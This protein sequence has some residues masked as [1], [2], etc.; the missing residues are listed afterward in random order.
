MAGMRSAIAGVSM[1]W[2]LVWAPAMAQTR[3]T[4]PLGSPVRVEGVDVEPV[5]RLEP[6]AVLRFTVFGTAGAS[7]A[8]QIAGARRPL[9]LREIHPGIY[10]GEYV[11]GAQDRVEP[12][13]RVKATLR[14]DG[15]VA[16]ALLEEPLV[17]SG[18]AP[19][20]TPRPSAH[21]DPTPPAEVFLARPLE[22]P[23]LRPAACANCAVVESV[24]RVEPEA[25][26]GLAGALAGGLAGAVIAGRAGNAPER[27]LAQVA[28]VLGGAW[29]GREIELRSTRAVVRYDLWLRLPDGSTQ[30][31]SYAS[32]PPYKPG[33]LVPLGPVR[34]AQGTLAPVPR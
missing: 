29:L 25:S 22:T 26:R 11:V 18:S 2:L 24:R 21:P 4:E 7:A 17:Q 20:A 9:D 28:A 19:L 27:H 13:G 12:D 23:I 31:R 8:L 15:L 34:M 32:P 16:W 6:G 33:D 30:I 10:E 5:E 1:T 3:A 14:R